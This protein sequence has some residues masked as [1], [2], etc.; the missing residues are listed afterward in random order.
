MPGPEL[1]ESLAGQRQFPDQLDEARVVGI[2]SDGLREN[3][4][5]AALT[6]SGDDL[7]ELNG[8]AA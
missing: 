6:L 4:T 7:T 2:G 3:V 8:I 5:G 1:P